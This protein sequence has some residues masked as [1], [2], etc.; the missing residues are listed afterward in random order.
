MC[1]P[2]RDTGGLTAL[3]AQPTIC[4]IRSGKI[5]LSVLSR[6][7]SATLEFIVLFSNFL[8]QFCFSYLS[9]VDPF[10]CGV[11]FIRTW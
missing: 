4:H 2:S 9:K 7:L 1:F 10:K 11:L 5:T 3:S 8:Y 6:E